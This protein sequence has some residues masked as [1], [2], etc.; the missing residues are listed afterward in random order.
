M[1]YVV[2]FNNIKQ[3]DLCQIFPLAS[4]MRTSSTYVYKK[5]YTLEGFYSLPSILITWFKCDS[6]IPNPLSLE[7]YPLLCVYD[8][9][10]WI[11]HFEKNFA[12]RTQL[13]NFRLAEILQIRSC[14][15]GPVGSLIGRWNHLPTRLTQIRSDYSI[16]EVQTG[17]CLKGVY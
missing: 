3:S 15:P 11:Q 7:H 2:L 9:E 5:S 13:K 1:D 4:V 17:G 8:R 6:L 12:S 16:E 10:V 14:K